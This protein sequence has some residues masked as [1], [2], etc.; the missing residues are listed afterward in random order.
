MAG[1][2]TLDFLGRNDFSRQARA[3]AA[4]AVDEGID[5]EAQMLEIMAVAAT[6]SKNGEFNEARA[7]QQ[8]T[9]NTWPCS[10]R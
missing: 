1:A 2:S 6:K 5:A 4:A 7:L 3:D 9:D 8:R 10:C